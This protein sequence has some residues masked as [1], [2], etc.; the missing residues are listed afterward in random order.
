M[1]NS[2]LAFKD[3]QIDTLSKEEQKIIRGGDD[4]TIDPN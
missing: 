3:F 2:K 1:K 4:T